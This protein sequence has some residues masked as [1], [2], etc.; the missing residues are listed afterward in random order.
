M[1]MILA[2][3]PGLAVKVHTIWVGR[4]SNLAAQEFLRQLAEAHG[5]TFQAVVSR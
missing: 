2:A 1:Q 3:N 4:E 5:G